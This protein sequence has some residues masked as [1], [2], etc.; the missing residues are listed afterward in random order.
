MGYQIPNANIIQGFNYNTSKLHLKGRFFPDLSPHPFSRFL[1]SIM[2]RSLSIRHIHLARSLATHA[3]PPARSATQ[4][5]R[6][7]WTREEIQAIYDTPLLDLVFRSASVHREHN[8]PS[9]VQLCTLMN[10]KSA[11]PPT[12]TIVTLKCFLKP[13]DVARTVRTY[14]LRA[15]SCADE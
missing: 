6:N 15:A 4:I 12:F 11:S 7:D 9:K 8:D 10:I 13:V 3:A 14:A 5:T 2:F 1:G